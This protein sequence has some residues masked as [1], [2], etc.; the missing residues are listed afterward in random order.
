MP[1]EMGKRRRAPLESSRTGASE[2]LRRTTSVSLVMSVGD[3][4]EVVLME[5]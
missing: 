3:A 4:S 1:R 2:I 5:S